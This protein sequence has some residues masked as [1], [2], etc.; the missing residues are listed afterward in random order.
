MIS[1]KAANNKKITEDIDSAILDEK[2]EINIECKNLLFFSSSPWCRCHVQT[3]L[4]TRAPRSIDS[5]LTTAQ[6]VERAL[7][8]TALLRIREMTPAPNAVIVIEW[9]RLKESF[10]MA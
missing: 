1:G 10:F 7:I 2:D 3:A 4:V 5:V 6:H 9:E 8:T